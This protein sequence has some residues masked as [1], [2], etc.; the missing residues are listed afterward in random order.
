MPPGPAH[1]DPDFP[2]G[3]EWRLVPADP[4]WLED[5]GYLAA[6][7]E[8]DEPDEP[9]LYQDPDNA[10]PTGLDDAGLAALLAGAREAGADR[11]WATAWLG[12]RGPA[13]PGS[14]RTFPGEYAGPAAGF[15]AGRELDTTPGCAGLALFA[16]DAAGPDD[17]Y[18]GASDDELVGAICA[19][20]RVEASAAARKHAAAAELIRRRPDPD[21]AP[22]AG[23]G[24]MPQTWEEF[25]PAELAPALGESRAAAEAVLDLASDLA[26]KL[27]GTRAAFLSGMVTLRKAAII[28]RA[29]EALDPAEARAAEAR[30]LDRAGR[31]TPGGLRAAIGRAVMEV[32][33]GKARKRRE[34]AARLARV[35][36]WG[37]D[38]GNGALAGRELPPAAVLAADQRV[39]AWAKQLKA[40]GLDGDM[41]QLRAQALLDLL[42][43]TDSR[44]RRDDTDGSDPDDRTGGRPG[45]S[46]P[47]GPERP[48]AAGMGGG[49][50]GAGPVDGA[51]PPGFAGKANL[52]IPLTTLTHLADR[53]GDLGGIGPIDPDLTRD[54]AAAAARNRRTTWCV[55]VTD[56]DGHAIG[57]GCARPEPKNARTGRAKRLKPGPAGG[58]DPPTRSGD[59]EGPR[60]S[61]IAVGRDGPPGGYG[62]W[63]LSTGEPGRPDLIIAIG[64]IATGSCDHRHEARGH[65]PGAVLRHLTEIR[66]ARCTAPGCRRPAVNCDFEHNI[67]YEAGGRSCE[68]NGGPKCRYDHRLKQHPR[69]KVEQPTPAVMVWTTPAGR[70][71]VTEPTRYPI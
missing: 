56:D 23:P 2:P 15:A 11:A 60:F 45:P 69:W 9:D 39:T 67:P 31:L 33:P 35:E 3:G 51:I 50:P 52:T 42:L 5:E 34:R 29:A 6:L 62:T 64:P 70:Q 49:W 20:D 21:G 30:V 40:A 16:E 68:C 47:A 63:R 44:P 22:A 41:D 32:A 55:T 25:T 36:R 46:G 71:Y 7:A 54:L 28:A 37:E 17:R 24:Q 8:E 59:R 58:H 38:S 53:P 43:G 12:R 65:D 57:H 4:G 19:W 27:P 14:A 18:L 13:M 26:V 1:P 66:H 61:F 48:G 10:P